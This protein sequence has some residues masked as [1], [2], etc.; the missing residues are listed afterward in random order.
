MPED[1]QRV[2]HLLLVD[3]AVP[4]PGTSLAKTLVADRPVVESEGTDLFLLF[5]QLW[6]NTIIER[7]KVGC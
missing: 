4:G 5:C 1:D 7:L 6:A 2:K 3:G